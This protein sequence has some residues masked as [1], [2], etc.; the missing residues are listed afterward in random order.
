MKYSLTLFA[1]LFFLLLMKTSSAQESKIKAIFIYK[2]IENTQWPNGNTN[3]TIGVVG[4]SE[5]VAELEKLLSSRNKTYINVRK[6]NVANVPEC[7]AV[8]IPSSNDED[9]NTVLAST[10]GKSIL[11]ITETSHL[12]KKGA[13][14]GFSMED[15]RLGY[16][17]NRSH[18]D[19]CRLKVTQN[20]VNMAKEVI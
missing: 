6:I 4:T 12:A 16:V 9:F 14:I 19:I 8:F 5:V 13:G 20:I 3:V 18:L 15:G 7:D 17:V 11:L 1:T 2:F 10:K